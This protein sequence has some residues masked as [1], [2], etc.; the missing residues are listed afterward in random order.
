MLLFGLSLPDPQLDLRILRIIVQ[1]PALDY[2][3]TIIIEGEP[4]SDILVRDSFLFFKKGQ[5]QNKEIERVE[6]I[7]IKEGASLLKVVH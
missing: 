3:E 7:R 5:T 4:V 2:I 6:T 1:W